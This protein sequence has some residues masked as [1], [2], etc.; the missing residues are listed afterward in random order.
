MAKRIYDNFPRCD[1]CSRE[2][3]YLFRSMVTLASGETVLGR[4][5]ARCREPSNIEREEMLDE[6]KGEPASKAASISEG[7]G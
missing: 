6:R 5:C 2:T 4:A 1:A 7:C 3:D